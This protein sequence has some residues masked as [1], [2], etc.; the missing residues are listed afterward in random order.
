MAMHI[1]HIIAYDIIVG[2][3]STQSLDRDRNVG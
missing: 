3:R 2:I 1:L